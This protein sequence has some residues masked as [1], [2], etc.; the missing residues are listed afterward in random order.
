MLYPTKNADGE[1]E[2][3]S[4]FEA[5]FHFLSIGFKVVYALCPPPHV[6]GGWACFVVAIIMI[7]ITT[8]VVGEVAALMGC[9]MGLK[10][11]VTAITFVAIGTSLPDTFASKTAAQ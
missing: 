3:V 1:I 2:D 4:G 5:L 9:V 7:G 11:G 6:W 8:A 10:P